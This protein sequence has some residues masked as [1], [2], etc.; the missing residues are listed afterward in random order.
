MDE[1]ED[2]HQDPKVER[3][4]KTENCDETRD[5]KQVVTDVIAQVYPNEREYLHDRH[6]QTHPFSK[7]HFTDDG[8]T[9]CGN[10]EVAGGE[11]LEES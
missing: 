2:V 5:W 3:Q 6:P 7:V 4:L 10:S 11:P 8:I 9:C 1:N